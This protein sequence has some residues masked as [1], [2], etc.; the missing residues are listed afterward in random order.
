MAS[1]ISIHDCEAFDYEAAID[2]VEILV[3]QYLKALADLQNSESF[4]Q[5]PCI[6]QNIA[7]YWRRLSFLL[8]RIQAVEEDPQLDDAMKSSLQ[9]ELASLEKIYLKIH[10]RIQLSKQHWTR[11]LWKASDAVLVRMDE[12]L[13]GMGFDRE[14]RDRKFVRD[15]QKQNLKRQAEHDN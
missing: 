1:I 2:E 11:A 12:L 7:T 6:M 8:T 4:E 14:H 13:Q 10:E 5:I 3:P 15:L 9:S